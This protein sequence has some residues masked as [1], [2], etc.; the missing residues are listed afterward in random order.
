MTTLET[1]VVNPVNSTR[2]SVTDTSM[3]E[4]ALAQA[5]ENLVVD[6]E[7][8]SCEGEDLE[9]QM[10]TV[11]LVNSVVD[12]TKSSITEG[13]DPRYGLRKRRSPG[14]APEGSVEQASGGGPAQASSRSASP[15]ATPPPVE[16]PPPSSDVQPLQPV[17]KT[18]ITHAR[19]AQRSSSSRGVK[20]QVTVPPSNQTKR[21]GKEAPIHPRMESLPEQSQRSSSAVLRHVRR[22]IVNP[23]L[24]KTHASVNKSKT[25][26]NQKPPVSRAQQTNPSS[27][28]GH[29]PNTTLEP[30]LKDESLVPTS[31][32][33]PN[34]LRLT[35]PQQPP[36]PKTSTSG[37]AKPKPAQCMVPCPLPPAVPCPLQ[38]TRESVEKKVTIQDPPEHTQ[39]SSTRSRIFSVDLDRKLK[40][41]RIYHAFSLSDATLFVA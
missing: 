17:Y 41:T 24:A 16:L 21:I 13:E 20:H 15:L 23:L 3:V 40:S 32:A 9:D 12:S 30:H 8:D 31:G 18:T 38:P 22:N 14:D 5:E 39:S 10:I 37:T 4:T 6:E 2:E 7:I 36:R 35:T 34:P 29:R 33:V 19:Q 28:T 27:R 26:R 11:A 1:R 25:P